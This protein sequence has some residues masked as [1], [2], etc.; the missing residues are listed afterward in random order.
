MA[1]T[2]LLDAAGLPYTGITRVDAALTIIQQKFS[3]TAEAIGVLE[4][5]IGEG[6]GGTPGTGDA[7]TNAPTATGITA[8]Q[9]ADGS[10]DITLAWNYTQ[11][12]VPADYMVLFWKQGPA[13]LGVPL[14]VDKA[15][16]LAATART[17]TFQGWNPNSN[18]RFG[19]AAGA[20]S[21]IGAAV[22]VGAIIAPTA[23]PDWADISAVGDYTGLVDGIPA[24]TVVANAS[25][26]KIAYDGTVHYRSPG[27]P[28]NLPAP[29]ALITGTDS[30]GSARYFIGWAYFQGANIADGFLVFVVEGDTSTFSLGDPHFE[31]GAKNAGGF[32]T[33]ITLKGYPSDRTLSFGVAAFRRTELGLEVGTIVS[34]AVS[35]DWQGINTGT[36]NYAGTIFGVDQHNFNVHSSGASVYEPA[37]RYT[38]VT[39]DGVALQGGTRSYNLLVYDPI[40]KTTLFSGNYYDLPV[41]PQ[42]A[43]TLAR[44]IGVYAGRV[45]QVVFSFPNTVAN[46]FLYVDMTNVSDFLL[47]T[48]NALYFVYDILCTES[49]QKIALDLQ[50]SDGTSL[51]DTGAVDQNGHASHPAT[52]IPDGLVFNV[53]YRRRIPLPA[54]FDGKTITRVMVACENDAPGTHVALVRGVG[55][56]NGD[57][58]DPFYVPVWIGYTETVTIATVATADAANGFATGANDLPARTTDVPIISTG[59][60]PQTN[61]LV[62]S[63]PGAL[64]AIGASRTLFAS[65]SFQAQSAYA[66]VGQ[67]L[68]GEGNGLQRYAGTVPN[69]LNAVVDLSFQTQG[70]HVVAL[71]GTGWEPTQVPGV[72]TNIPTPAAASVT[73]S[74]TGSE[75]VQIVW[76]Y[77]QPAL[78]GDNKPADGFIVF[79]KGGDDANPSAGA[80]ANYKVGLDAYS[81]S[82]ESPLNQS[83][84]FA[85]AAYRKTSNGTEVGP[86]VTS[87]FAPDWQGIGG[88]TQVSENGLANEAAATAKIKSNAVTSSRRQLVLTLTASYTLANASHSS[89]TFTHSLGRIPLVT[90]DTNHISIHSTIY[91][92]TSSQ[93]HVDLF[94]VEDTTALPPSVSGTV[95]VFFW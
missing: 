81:F 30:D 40:G 61:R 38:Q 34:S 58:R 67:P 49:N 9:N 46:N 82:M 65:D 7:P 20:K 12:V 57:V 71:S 77:T 83:W 94:N 24:D 22:V 29:G 85:V 75:V 62:G 32:N 23:A 37:L 86:A 59:E 33:F 17:F 90:V 55:F 60:E 73:T 78:E 3:A 56:T 64:T 80:T 54:A 84:S 95:E 88:N 25:E 50:C 69:D 10:F 89:K 5:A 2:G 47:G 66:L 8:I 4:E 16:L 15:V 52:P 27:A 92:L 79:V 31:L 26:G 87:T 48:P 44:D 51:R 21:D 93:I 70:G 68:L 13:A 19:I 53:W 35:P 39:R 63:L 1:D 74:A 72:P 14:T 11:G 43:H 91:L 28:S 41:A 45:L 6:E 42:W 76:G 18:Y 36:P